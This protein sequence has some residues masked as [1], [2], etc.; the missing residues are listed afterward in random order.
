L[1]E[2]LGADKKKAMI[3]LTIQLPEKGSE[4]LDPYVVTVT[5]GEGFG[6]LMPCRV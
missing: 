4:M 2:A 5:Y 3:H 6:V 1:A